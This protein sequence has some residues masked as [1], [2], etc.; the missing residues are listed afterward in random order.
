[1]TTAIYSSFPVAT[2][3]KQRSQEPL[4]SKG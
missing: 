4:L 2:K 3:E 1:L